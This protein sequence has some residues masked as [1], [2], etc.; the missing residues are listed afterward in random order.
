MILMRKEVSRWYEKREMEKIMCMNVQS[1]LVAYKCT[2]ME[3]WG[4]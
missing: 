4:N 1:N 3:R 2:V